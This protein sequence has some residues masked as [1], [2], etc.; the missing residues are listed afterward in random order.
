MTT[1]LDPARTALVLIDFMPR[2]IALPLAPRSGDEALRAACALAERCAAAGA[3]VVAVRVDRPGV[4]AQPPGSELHPAVAEVAD[5]VLVKGTVGAFHATGLD[6]LL[7][8]RGITTLVLGGIATNMGVESTARAADD[9]DYQLVFA[10]DTMTALSAE[11]HAAAI[12][13]DFPRF[14]TVTTGPELTLAAV[15]A[16]PAR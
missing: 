16:H 5:Q 6:A 12:R 3:L 11:E 2:I 10:E 15:P 9:L 8:D 14:G 1:M 4:E 13:L 7:R